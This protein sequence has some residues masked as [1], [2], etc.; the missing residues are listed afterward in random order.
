[1]QGFTNGGHLEAARS[2][3]GEGLVLTEAVASD[4]EAVILSLRRAELDGA[5]YT[6]LRLERSQVTSRQLGSLL[7]LLPQVTA[8]YLGGCERLGHEGLLRSLLGTGVARVSLTGCTWVQM[9]T[10]RGLWDGGVEVVVYAGCPGVRQRQARKMDA[11]RRRRRSSEKRGARG[12]PEYAGPP[13]ADDDVGDPSVFESQD[14]TRVFGWGSVVGRS[15]EKLFYEPGADGGSRCY[16]GEVM[17]LYGTNAKGLRVYRVRYEDGD[18]EDVD[19]VTLGGML[20][21]GVRNRE[22]RAWTTRVARDAGLR[23][24]LRALGRRGGGADLADLA[25]SR[26]RSSARRG[27]N[28]AMREGEARQRARGRSDGGGAAPGERKDSMVLSAPGGQ[29]R[30]GARARQGRRRLRR[31]RGWRED[32]GDSDELG[33]EEGNRAA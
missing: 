9:D 30:G 15:V 23:G 20:V 25:A 16:A 18:V 33:A 21:P 32:D 27:G 7:R 8:V 29:A 10:L 11:A 24:S 1:M 5:R 3:G 6:R 19:E 26:A 13:W 28:P 4:V 2:E 17:A 12:H 31:A 14:A 22:W